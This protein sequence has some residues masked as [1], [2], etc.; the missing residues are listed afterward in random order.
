MIP[1]APD[2]VGLGA[3]RREPTTVVRL[4][5]GSSD[6]TPGPFTILAESEVPDV[7]L[8]WTPH[9]HP[10]HE[11]VWVRGGT[12]ASR[13]GNRVFTVPEGYGLWMPAEVMHAGR[14]TA[15]VEFHNAFFA[16]DR[17]PVAF[18]EPTAIAMSAVLESLLMYLTRRDLDAAAR[19]RAEAVV[20]DVLE[21]STRQLALRL[22][23]DDRID[24]IAE[25]LLGDSADGRSL[26]DWARLL[27]ISD[28]T[29]TRAFRRTTGLSFAQWRQALRIH[30]ALEL[31]SEGVD[32]Q[33]AAER[34]GYAQPSTFIAA[35]RRVMGITPGAFFG[36][37][38]TAPNVRN[39]VSVAPKS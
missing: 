25:A 22:P 30:Q 20:F 9:S 35:F 39:P 29:I 14:L 15:N 16:P 34:L 1:P 26:D 37:L 17:T 38:H 4:P 33:D 8:E 28:R 23:G 36:T 3:W 24:A 19:T 11:L 6:D 27:G 2:D 5:A 7:P 18:T 10:T 32:V 31:L 13:V 21:P 12:L